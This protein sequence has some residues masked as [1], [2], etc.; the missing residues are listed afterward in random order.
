MLESQENACHGVCALGSIT[1]TTVL[2]EV[3]F[4]T[5]VKL[6]NGQ[7]YIVSKTMSRRKT[8]GGGYK[9]HKQLSKK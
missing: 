5:C 4:G 3:F 1:S 2:G 9:W 6:K 7:I 8:T